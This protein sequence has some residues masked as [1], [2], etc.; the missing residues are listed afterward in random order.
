[1]L[2]NTS[3][4]S[5][6]QIGGSSKSAKTDSQK[7]SENDNQDAENSNDNNHEIVHALNG[8]VNSIKIYPRDVEKSDMLK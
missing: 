4:S 7:Q 3:A 5:T 1:V 2:L 6:S 8:S